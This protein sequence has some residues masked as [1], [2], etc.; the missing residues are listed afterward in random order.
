MKKSAI[1]QLSILINDRSDNLGVT[2]RKLFRE[3]KKGK[4]VFS[5]C[6]E[7]VLTLHKEAEKKGINY[8]HPHELNYIQELL[9]FLTLSFLFYFDEPVVTELLKPYLNIEDSEEFEQTKIWN[10]IDA[11][12]LCLSSKQVEIR[13]NALRC[14]HIILLTDQVKT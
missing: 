5:I 8:M 14:L 3:K 13:K 7:E 1:E 12:K 11:L 4:D 6:V 2:G 9:R 10:L